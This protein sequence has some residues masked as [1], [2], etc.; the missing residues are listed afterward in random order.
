MNKFWFLVTNFLKRKF[1]SKAFIFSVVIFILAA[2]LLSLLPKFIGGSKKVAITPKVPNG[3]VIYIYSDKETFTTDESEKLG[4]KIKERLSKTG[5]TCNLDFEGERPFGTATTAKTK[6]NYLLNK[7]DEN[8]KNDYYLVILYNKNDKNELSAA[9]YIRENNPSFESIIEN[10]IRETKVIIDES[11]M[12]D[13]FE[14]VRIVSNESFKMDH[15]ILITIYM[16]FAIFIIMFSIQNTGPDVVMEK[17]NRVIEQIMLNVS[18]K[19]HLI[20]KVLGGLI[21]TVS[22]L[23]II[24]ACLLIS[25]AIFNRTI[26]EAIKLMFAN[27]VTLK[28]LLVSFLAILLGSFLY[29]LIFVYLGALSNNME[30][31]GV[32]S[33]P[34]IAI[35]IVVMQVTSVFS[36]D[37]LSFSRILLRV[38]NYIPPLSVFA[39]PMGY[40]AG[41]FPLWESLIG[42]LLNLL[43][44]VGVIFIMSPTYKM[45]ILNYSNQRRLF[46]RIVF[47]M[48]QNREKKKMERENKKKWLHINN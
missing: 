9:Y 28:F 10:I 22:L 36:M 5:I 41:F 43:L 47:Y 40:A 48:K 11:S 4:N 33:G 3:S 24:I 6:L 45:A 17:S 16:V 32:M 42:V 13:N 39:S 35:I 15:R 8:I 7:K 37:E 25:S 1:K 14:K 19:K 34:F 21:F 2:I 27:A 12:I 38:L 20:S 46:S 44:A 29:L 23:F 31:Y 26:F 18:D 30:D